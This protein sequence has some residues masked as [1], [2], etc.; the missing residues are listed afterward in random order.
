MPSDIPE[1]IE[2][3]CRERDSLSHELRVAKSQ[4]ADIEQQMESTI[5]RSNHLAIEAQV[6]AIEA[7]QIFDASADAIWVINADL[8]VIKANRSML[9][10]LGKTRNEVVGGKCFELFPLPFCGTERCMVK[11]IKGGS[12]TIEVDV[13]HTPTGGT[14]SS[15][16]VTGSPFRGLEGETLGMVSVFK[17]ITE[18][19]VAER[20]MQQLANLDGLTLVA[21]RRRFDEYI[22]V[23]WKRAARERTDLSFILCD[24]DHFKLYNDRYGHPAG[25]DCL[26]RV[27]A[28]IG[29]RLKRPAD[30]VARYGGEEFA[31]VLPNTHAAGAIH[32]AE[33]ICHHIESL[34]LRHEGAGTAEVITLSLGVASVIPTRDLT[35]AALIRAA[36]LALYEAKRSGRNRVVGAKSVGP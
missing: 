24:V 21:N 35:V 8:K 7:Q 23:E 3:L 12:Q 33:T 36:D 2:A 32:V 26:K 28:A 25:D 5:A 29:D 34:R 9:K 10:L 20:V 27:A 31:I 1:S 18:R 30:L 11:C 16:I 22:A 19:K 6:A 17:D 14:P 13:E 15:F 4:L